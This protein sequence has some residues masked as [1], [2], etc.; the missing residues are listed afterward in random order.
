MEGDQ[1]Q[2]GCCKCISWL[3]IGTALGGWWWTYENNNP[4]CAAVSR[5]LLQENV[6]KRNA[7][8]PLRGL[9]ASREELNC[10]KYSELQLNAAF[11][12]RQ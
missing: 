6:K 8:K 3:C 4:A 11:R 7:S 10:L 1:M 2:R 9:E 12:P 5:V